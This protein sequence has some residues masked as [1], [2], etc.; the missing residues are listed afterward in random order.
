[1]SVSTS[2]MFQIRMGNDFGFYSTKNSSAVVFLFRSLLHVVAANHNSEEERFQII[3][4][5]LAE[6]SSEKYLPHS[7]SRLLLHSLF[8]YLNISQPAKTI[9]SQ[10]NN[11]R[12]KAIWPLL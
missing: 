2:S 10:K 4:S 3:S 9:Q 12:A 11:V 5:Q 1:M 6:I 8:L 7:D